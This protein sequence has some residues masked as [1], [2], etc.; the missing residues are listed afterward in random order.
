MLVELSRSITTKT[1]ASLER[2]EATTRKQNKTAAMVSPSVPGRQ[3]FAIQ[4]VK[5]EVY[6]C[7]TIYLKEASGKADVALMTGTRFS[8]GS[9]ADEESPVC[10]SSLCFW[11]GALGG[12][13]ILVRHFLGHISHCR[14]RDEH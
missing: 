8:R 9:S 4:V 14:A 7:P 11:P 1:H 6:I 2:V 5:T 12:W 13:Q 10:S 3:T